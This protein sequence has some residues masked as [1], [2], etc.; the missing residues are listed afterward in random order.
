MLSGI[1]S[2]REAIKETAAK[3]GTVGWQTLM[4]WQL[5]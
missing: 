4:T 2:P 3:T 1:F 5:P